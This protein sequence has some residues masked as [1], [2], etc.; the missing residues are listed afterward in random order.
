MELLERQLSMIAERRQ[1]QLLEKQEIKTTDDWLDELQKSEQGKIISNAFNIL[2]ILLN[3]QK[4]KGKFG[5]NLLTHNAEIVGNVPWQRLDEDNGMT[6]HDDSCL[7]N[8]ISMQYGI[9]AKDVIFDSLAQVTSDKKY[10]PIRKYLESLKWDEKPRLDTL[11]VDFFGAD[12]TELNRWQTRLSMAAAVARIFY[13]GCKWDYVPT[14]KGGQGL[15]KSTFLQEIAVNGEWFTD[16]LDDMRG[17]AAKEQL[18]GKWIIE[19]GEMAAVSKSDQKRTKQ[20]ISSRTDE[21]RPAFGRRTVRF[22]RQCIFWATTNDEEPLKDDTGGRRYWI[23]DVKTKWFEKDEP[24]ELD[25]IWAE[26]V[27]VCQ[28]MMANKIPFKLPDYLE[29]EANSIQT[30][31]TDRGL[32][33]SII[34]DVLQRGYI[35]ELDYNSV[36]QVPV[37]ETCAFHVWEKVLGRHRNEFNSAHA[38]DIN[39]VLRTLPGWEQVKGRV[40]FGQ[41][42]KQ[43]VYKRKDS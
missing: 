14:L 12:D 31:N 15:G 23:I 2:L 1:K 5:Y 42:G 32:Y 37:N 10:H 7:R 29:Y 17:T 26:A 19:L 21:F 34:E 16:S 40:K 25:Q 33:A 27:R 36:K 3:D 41:Y 4:L 11:L 35:E 13:P 6:D 30:Q 28:E 39:A 22:A 9:K 24:L 8:Y 43:T 20:F 18:R 38:R